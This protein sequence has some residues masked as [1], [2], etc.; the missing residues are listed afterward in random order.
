MYSLFVRMWRHRASRIEVCIAGVVLILL[1]WRAAHFWRFL[2]YFWRF[3]CTK[4]A[5]VLK[6]V[7]VSSSQR[8]LRRCLFQHFYYFRGS[9]CSQKEVL[10]LT[11]W[12]FS[13]FLPILSQ[14][15]K[16]NIFSTKYESGHHLRTRRRLCAKF[17]VLRRRD[18]ISVSTSRSRDA[19]T[20]RL[21]LGYLR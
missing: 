3:L 1:H 20:S 21:G 2:T 4:A 11:F 8:G 13:C 6:K 19:P 17:D 12:P 15:E 18:V 16:K 9:E 7:T 10:F 14:L 5:Q